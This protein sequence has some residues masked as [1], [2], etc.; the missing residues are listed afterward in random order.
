MS[1]TLPVVETFHSLQ[2]KGLHAGRSALFLRLVGCT[3]GCPW[4]TPNTPGRRRPIR[5]EESTASPL[6][7]QKRPLQGLPL[8]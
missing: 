5:K 8:R 3:V 2:G 6:P 1:E 7:Q 4:A